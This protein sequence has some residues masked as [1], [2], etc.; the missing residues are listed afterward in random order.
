MITD[1]KI[2]IFVPE[3]ILKKLKKGIIGTADRDLDFK[4]AEYL[5]KYQILA[6]DWESGA[7]AKICELNKVEC[8][9]L[10]GVS[11]K[12]SESTE[13]DEQ[14]QAMEYKKN[15]P[16]VMKKLF[17]ITE[18]ILTNAYQKEFSNKP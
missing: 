13:K 3:S 14:I 6:A 11:D 18:L 16:L 12:P 9:I 4:T 1:L 15:T 2:P 5:K 17:R 7:I 10:R 8:L